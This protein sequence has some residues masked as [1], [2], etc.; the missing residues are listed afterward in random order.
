MKVDLL[1]QKETKHPAFR[2]LRHVLIKIYRETLQWLL[3]AQ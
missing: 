3:V 1:V 2:L